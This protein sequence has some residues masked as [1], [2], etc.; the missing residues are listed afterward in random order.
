MWKC[1]LKLFSFVEYIIL[2]MNCNESMCLVIEGPLKKGDTYVP[3]LVSYI[4]KEA[5]RLPM[6]NYCMCDFPCHCHSFKPSS[7]R[8]L[9]FL[10]SYS[11]CCKVSATSH[12]IPTISCPYQVWSEPPCLHHICSEQAPAQPSELKYWHPKNI[13]VSTEKKL[14]IKN[15]YI[16]R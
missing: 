4:E 10:H 14:T 11:V 15:S 9:P 6:F 13:D 1:W 7:W 2:T 8:L 3:S 16:W 12:I 5:K